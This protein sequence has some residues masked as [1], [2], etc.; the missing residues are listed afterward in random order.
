MKHQVEGRGFIITR[1]CGHF[2]PLHAYK[3]LYY[4]ASPDRFVITPYLCAVTEA[5]AASLLYP[6]DFMKGISVTFCN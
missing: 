2:M 1:V 5:Y 6:M 3:M 4:I